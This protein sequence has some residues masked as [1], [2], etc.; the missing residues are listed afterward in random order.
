MKI[1]KIIFS[2]FMITLSILFIL[3]HQKTFEKINDWDTEHIEINDLNK[4]V[5]LFNHLF[6]AWNDWFYVSLLEHIL[7]LDIN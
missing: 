4:N 1:L 3:N 6:T 5:L 2:I 7:P